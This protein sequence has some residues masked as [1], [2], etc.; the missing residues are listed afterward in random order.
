[1]PAEIDR[2]VR[3]PISHPARN[4]FRAVLTWELCV[5]NFHDIA[6]VLEPILIEA[7]R[8]TQSEKGNIQV[9]DGS[10]GCLTIEAHHGFDDNFL[11]A[12]K[13]VSAA[14]G[15]ACGRAIRSRVPIVIA[16]VLL[17]DEYAPYR[18]AAMEAG[19]RSVVS[20]PLIAR[21]SIVGVIS[22]HRAS[23]GTGEPDV[24]ALRGVA[25]FAAEAISRH[26]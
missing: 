19:F 14:N 16:D 23:P 8:L 26:R 9:F 22:I 4:V 15:C 20:L 12:F 21:G 10:S 24:E 11:E 6:P 1:M 25:E 17:D 3:V 13:S 2:A 7:L 5:M 18:Q